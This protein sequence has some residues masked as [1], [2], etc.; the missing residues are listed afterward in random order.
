MGR[1]LYEVVGR[2]DTAFGKHLT[3]NK[4]VCVSVC[5]KTFQ[6]SLGTFN[7]SQMAVLTP[8]IWSALGWEENRSDG[9][10]VPFPRA[11]SPGH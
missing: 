3:Y 8:A 4:T 2:A 6:T 9:V 7:R 1:G 5:V 11:E 10:Q